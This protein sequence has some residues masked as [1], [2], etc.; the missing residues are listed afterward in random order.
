MPVL[1]EYLY[2]FFEERKS[3]NGQDERKAQVTIT[4]IFKGEGL[5]MMGGGLLSC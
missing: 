2:I 5:G 1:F 3:R 4:S